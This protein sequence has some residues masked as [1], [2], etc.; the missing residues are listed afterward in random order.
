M[1]WF[2]NPEQYL[3]GMNSDLPKK[4]KGGRFTSNDVSRPL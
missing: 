4:T 2:A 3:L 1:N